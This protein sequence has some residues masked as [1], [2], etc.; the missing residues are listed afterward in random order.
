[1]TEIPPQSSV[2]QPMAAD[3]RKALLAQVVAQEVAHGARVES[4]TDFQAVVVRGQRVNHVLHLILTLVTC[5][6]WG[7]VWAALAIIGGEKR[8]VLA[9]DDWGNIQRR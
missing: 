6:A 5:L 3:Q 8:T 1:M 4:H 2:P 7:L 9:I